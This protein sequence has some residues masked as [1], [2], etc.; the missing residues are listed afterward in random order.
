[1][2]AH[3]NSIRLCGDSSSTHERGSS[4]VCFH[5]AAQRGFEPRTV[6]ARR[7]CLRVMLSQGGRL[8]HRTGW[9]SAL[10]QLPDVFCNSAQPPFADRCSTRLMLPSQWT[11]V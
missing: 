9:A 8:I 4:G 6:R 5:M 11:R 1:M 2:E 7:G 3:S 10:A